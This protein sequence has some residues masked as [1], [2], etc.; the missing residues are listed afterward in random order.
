M[1]WTATPVA[2]GADRAA[3]AGR[4]AAGDVQAVASMDFALPA[5]DQTVTEWRIGQVAVRQAARLAG[6]DRSAG[7]HSE[8]DRAPFACLR[9]SSTRAR[10][11]IS[12]ARPSHGAAGGSEPLRWLA[13]GSEWHITPG[14]GSWKILEPW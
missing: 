13:S 4:R 12:S 9:R 11:E 6:P 7:G 2:P 1:I 8:P 10:R 5:L 3:V 14:N